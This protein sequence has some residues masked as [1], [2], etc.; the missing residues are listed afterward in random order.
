MRKEWPTIDLVVPK[1]SLPDG[2]TWKLL[3]EIDVPIVVEKLRQWYPDIIVGLESRHLSEDFY[4]KNFSFKE[5]TDTNKDYLGTVL[6]HSGTIVGL[7]TFERNTLQ[8]TLNCPMGAL[9]HDH[10]GAG[11]LYCGQAMLELMGRAIGAEMVFFTPTLKHPHQQIVAEKMGYKLVG[12]VPAH[13]R[14]MV[15]KGISKRVFEAVYV[16]VLVDNDDLFLPKRKSLTPQTQKLW[17][18][19]FGDSDWSL[20]D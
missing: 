19:L 16:K 12:I 14:D 18:Y 20:R 5:E 13:D 3:N 2:Y 15:Q 6:W 8:G 1:E 11:I 17:D 9:A 7:L 10:R 4:R